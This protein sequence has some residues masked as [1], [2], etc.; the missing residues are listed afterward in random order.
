LSSRAAT[1]LLSTLGLLGS[2]SWFGG[3]TEVHEEEFYEQDPQA[4][5]VAK[6]TAK[7]ANIALIIQNT[8]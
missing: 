3:T 7:E 1:S 6:Q 4:E 8:K 5:L 2:S